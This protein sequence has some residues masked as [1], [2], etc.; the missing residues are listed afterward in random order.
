MSNETNQ[1]KLARLEREL[2]Q[3]KSTLPEHCSGATDYI[4]VHRA[5]PAHWQKIEDLEAEIERL[6]IETDG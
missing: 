2:A 4:E 1:E 3:L 5:S 6:R